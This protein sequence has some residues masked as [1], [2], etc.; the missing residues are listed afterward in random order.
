MEVSGELRAPAALPP[1]KEPLVPMRMS[2]FQSRSGHG[3]EEKSSKPLS[4]LK[5]PIVQPVSQLYNTEISWL[6]S[7]SL[8]LN[9]FVMLK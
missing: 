6:P 8:H 9:I 4:G 3:G 7:S 5:I 1:G 2:G